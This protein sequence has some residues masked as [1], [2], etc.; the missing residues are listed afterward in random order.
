MFC[1]VSKYI[2]PKKMSAFPPNQIF[3]QSPLQSLKTIETFENPSFE[4][5]R[6]GAQSALNKELQDFISSIEV[7]PYTSILQDYQLT[8]L[9]ALFFSVSNVVAL[10]KE[11]RK[12]VYDLANVKLGPQSEP[13][14]VLLMLETYL[15]KNYQTD[16]SSMSVQQANTYCKSKINIMNEATAV[17][18]VNIIVQNLREY[19]TF[20]HQRKQTLYIDPPVS[21]SVQGNLEYRE[22]PLF[23]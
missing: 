22:N 13:E 15:S 4:P 5:W 11:I 7:V 14:L 16:E 20:Q 9:L 10:E 17:R 18:A 8:L 1:V 21:T 23:Q 2:E 6:Q 12:R 3:F 19:V